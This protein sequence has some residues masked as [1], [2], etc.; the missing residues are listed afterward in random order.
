MHVFYLVSF[1]IGVPKMNNRP[2]K[3]S[4]QT[5]IKHLMNLDDTCY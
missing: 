5:H 1:G 3:L 2:I 4:L